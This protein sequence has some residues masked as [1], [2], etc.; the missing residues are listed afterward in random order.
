MMLPM[1]KCGQLFSR[2]RAFRPAEYGKSNWWLIG[3]R[4]MSHEPTGFGWEF[5]S[6]EEIVATRAIGD[7]CIY[8]QWITDPE[9]ADVE[10]EWCPQ[11]SQ[12]L[13]RNEMV[14][15]NNIASMGFKKKK[16]E[17]QNNPITPTAKIIRL[18]KLRLPGPVSW[19]GDA[20]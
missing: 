3:V 17:D 6:V 15:R 5:L 9:G 16:N 2:R 1:L 11:R 18:G 19:G 8:H 13:F 20:A 14:L 4:T 10:H 7:L 12:H